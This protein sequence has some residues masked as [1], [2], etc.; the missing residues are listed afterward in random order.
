MNSPTSMASVVA[1]KERHEADADEDQRHAGLVGEGA[2]GDVRHRAALPW[3]PVLYFVRARSS[4][5]PPDTPL[6]RPAPCRGSVDRACFFLLGLGLPRRLLGGLPVGLGLAATL[7]GVALRLLAR[8]LLLL[9]SRSFSLA[10]LPASRL[11]AFACARASAA[12]RSALG[13]LRALRGA[14]ARP[15]VSSRAA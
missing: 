3:R 12:A 11:A 14:A 2:E 13:L 9:A 8:E 15:P 6:R 10:L 4:R 1:G 7:L 5:A